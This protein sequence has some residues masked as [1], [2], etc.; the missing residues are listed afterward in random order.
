M[1]ANT[2]RKRN[3]DTKKCWF[4]ITFLVKFIF[5]LLGLLLVLNA[6]FV[7]AQNTSPYDDPLKSHFSLRSGYLGNG[8]GL[9]G[10]AD[11]RLLAPFRAAAE[12]HLLTDNYSFLIIEPAFSWRFFETALGPAVLFT[13]EGGVEPYVRL[14]VGEEGDFYLSGRTLGLLDQ[15]GGIAPKLFGAEMGLNLTHTGVL[16]IGYTFTDFDPK[17]EG[18]ERDSAIISFKDDIDRSLSLLIAGGASFLSD[19]SFPSYNFLV[20]LTYKF[21]HGFQLGGFS[22]GDLWNEPLLIQRAEE[23]EEN[24]LEQAI[25]PPGITYI[26]SSSGR[27]RVEEHDWHKVE[28]I[29]EDVPYLAASLGGGYM[30]LGFGGGT[31]LDYKLGGP[32]RV[33]IGIGTNQ[34]EGELSYPFLFRPSYSFGLFP[35]IPAGDWKFFQF[36]LGLTGGFFSSGGRTLP[37]PF[38]AL[39]LRVGAEDSIYAFLDVGDVPYSAGGTSGAALGLGWGITP[40][41]TIALMAGAPALTDI[42]DFTNLNIAT[43]STYPPL[44]LRLRPMTLLSWEQGL[45][46]LDEFAGG[47]G[48]TENLFL[49]LGAGVLVSDFAGGTLSGIS[50]VVT[51]GFSYN[52]EFPPINVGASELM[53]EAEGLEKEGKWEEAGET[54]RKIVSR[55]PDNRW[56]DEAVY[57]NAFS[58]EKIDMPEEALKEYTR[59]ATDYPT[60]EWNALAQY[61]LGA[62]AVRDA[63]W[64]AVYKSF[65]NVQNSQPQSD[66]ARRVSYWAQYSLAKLENRER[67]EILLEEFLLFF[68]EGE[69]SDDAFFQLGEIYFEEG[70]Y[71]EALERY[72]K[73]VENYPDSDKAAIAQLMIGHSLF[74]SGQLSQAEAEYKKVSENYPDR[75]EL[76]EEA[77]GRLDELRSGGEERE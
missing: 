1:V 29:Y 45:A 12:F 21:N 37:I 71:R 17:V 8:I 31:N 44:T 59:L 16:A 39:L 26:T 32:F 40:S 2:R 33:E 6:H 57:K 10:R 41:T 34:E 9:E 19:I 36:G 50:P 74:R 46:D 24:L 7:S 5:P 15:D 77:Q 65:T 67:A 48:L 38:P 18:H 55:Y 62:R 42:F 58:Y 43:L 72:E 68:P 56:V 63:K 35:F 66:T 61:A 64:N 69:L 49:Q 47:I 60:S 14:R 28:K 20:G 23:G 22:F 25:L 53:R 27:K 75:A 30:G 13:P 3:T 11:Y 70:R 51:I 52:T 73:I 54:Y 76:V 4:R